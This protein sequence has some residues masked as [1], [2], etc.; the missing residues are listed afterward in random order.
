MVVIVKAILSKILTNFN[1]ENKIPRLSKGDN[2]GNF[3]SNLDNQ[4]EKV[5]GLFK[6]DNEG[7]FRSNLDKYLSGK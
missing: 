3:R 2:E 1:Q 4:E 5:P 6:D 7:Y